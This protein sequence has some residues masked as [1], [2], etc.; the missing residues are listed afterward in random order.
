MEKASF[1]N[2]VKSSKKK[3]LEIVFF[4]GVLFREKLRSEAAKGLIKI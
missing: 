4:C 2:W 3:L 1:T